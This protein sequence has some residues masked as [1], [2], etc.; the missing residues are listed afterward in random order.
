MQAVQAVLTL[1]A[2]GLVQARRV[3][4]PVGRVTPGDLFP[5]EPFFVELVLLGILAFQSG[6]QIVANRVLGFNEVPTR[7]LTSVNCDIASDEKLFR[8]DNERRNRRVS[9]VVL[10]LLGGIGGGWISRSEAGIATVLW[11]GGYLKL[12]IAIAWA[13]WKGE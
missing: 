2:V 11:I 1:V 7:V 8:R 6:G 10:L 13:F 4:V 9:G 12:E 3:P 5:G